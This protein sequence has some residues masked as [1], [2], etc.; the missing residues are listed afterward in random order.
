MLALL[1]LGVG[2]FSIVTIDLMYDVG[3]RLEPLISERWNYFGMQKLATAVVLRH[4]GGIASAVAV[5]QLLRVGIGSRLPDRSTR[6]LVWMA[7][8]GVQLVAFCLWFFTVAT[9]VMSNIGLF[10]PS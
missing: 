7:L 9:A 10:R 5:T 6:W 1:E 3:W 4:R 8:A 2:A